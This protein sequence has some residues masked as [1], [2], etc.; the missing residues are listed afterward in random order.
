[1]AFLIHVNGVNIT[2]TLAQHISEGLTF[3]ALSQ[4]R[5]G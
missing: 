2:L 1:V 3:M 5:V 4:L